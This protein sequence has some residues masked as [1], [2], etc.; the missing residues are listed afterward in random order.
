MKYEKIRK[1][2]VDVCLFL[3]DKGYVFGTWGNVSV[4]LPDGNMLITPSRIDYAE[5]RTE[6][7][8]EITTDGKI[9]L[10]DKLPTSEREIHCGIMRIRPDVGA[11][12]HTHSPSAMACCALPDGIPV[13]SEEMCQL[14]N[15]E[16]RVTD[17][18]VPSDEHAELGREVCR[19]I[20]NANAL[21][22]KNHG[23]VCLGRTLKEAL[24]CCQVVEKTADNYL[25]L[26][27][28]NLPINTLGKEFVGRGRDYFIN[29]YGK[30]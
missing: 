10:G 8:V 29:K 6:D 2:I 18:F 9:I 17:K 25:K 13:I 21:L 28:T 1:E 27:A 5:M 24:V 16:I 11:V 7:I 30:S 4:R 12:I 15:G 14:L 3:R 23:P 20:G 26:S 19:K 22:I